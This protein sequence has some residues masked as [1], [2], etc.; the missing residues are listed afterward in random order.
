VFLALEK[1]KNRKSIFAGKLELVAV[2]FLC[3][4][5]GIFAL[6][7]FLKKENKTA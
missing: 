2:V 1:D 3:A 6:M 5:I 7:Y 4:I